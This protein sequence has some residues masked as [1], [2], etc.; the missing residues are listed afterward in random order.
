[1]EE[2]PLSRLHREALVTAIWEG[3]S[4]IQALDLLEA[5]SRK[6]AH[7]PF[8]DDFI[9]HLQRNGT[10][11][12]RQASAVLQEGL[13]GLA[14]GKAELAQWMSKDALRRLADA[15]QVA[16]LYGLAEGTGGERYARLAALY[17][18]RFL[19]HEPY[20]AW[21]LQDRE[22]WFPFPD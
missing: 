6:G 2:F 19:G 10:Q 18:H 22:I 11:E 4:N 20:P 5:I 12:A 14:E 13:A 9:P 17:A 3:T 16:L 15:A 8:L 21:A 1:M 7:E